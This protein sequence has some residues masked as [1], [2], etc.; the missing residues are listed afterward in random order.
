MKGGAWGKKG[1]GGME[2]KFWEVEDS[3][4]LWNGTTWF[5]PSTSTVKLQTLEPKA[6]LR[7]FCWYLWACLFLLD[8]SALLI[9]STQA[10]GFVGYTMSD[11]LFAEPKK[12][13][14]QPIIL[15]MFTLDF[16]IYVSNKK[17]ISFNNLN[18]SKHLISC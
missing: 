8:V 2:R 4:E 12:L 18:K 17:T 10:Q 14:K 16:I 5:L 15:N 3:A 7:A 13:K 1:R 6:F 9:S 11:L